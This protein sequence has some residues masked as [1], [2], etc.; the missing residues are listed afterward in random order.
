MYQLFSKRVSKP[1]MILFDVGGTLFDDSKCIPFDGL[2][3]LRQ[4]AENPD[5]TD[6]DTLTA[7]WDEYISDVSGLKSHSGITLDFPLSAA[8]RYTAMKAGLRFSIP[9]AKQEEIFD[10]FNSSR[11]VIDGI[12]ELLDT[13]HSLG[14]RTA[15]ISNNAMSGDGLALAI[16]RWI[17]NEKMEFFLT[18]A[19]ILLTKPC[20]DIFGCAANYAGISPDRCWYCGDGKTPDVYG[21]KGAGM[22]PVLLDTVSPLPSEIRTDEQCGEYTAINRWDVLREYLLGL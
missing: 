10:R 16:K 15:V 20:A 3:A 19:D 14:I 22:T 13:I 7:I 12:P 21:A 4:R 18:S 5:V 2:S 6:D 11:K 8:I 9:M 17:P 1:E